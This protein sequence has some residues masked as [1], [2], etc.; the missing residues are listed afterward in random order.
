MS[1]AT[2]LLPT[3]QVACACQQLQT[4]EGFPWARYLPKPR[5]HDA[6]GQVG[7]PFRD[8]LFSPAVTLWAFLSQVLDHDHSCRQVMARLFA[9]LVARGRRPRSADTGAYCKA[10]ARFPEA[11]LRHLARDTGRQP[12]DQ[13]PA[14]WLWKGRVVKVVDGTGLSMPD[15]PANQKEYPHH[16][17]QKPGAGFPLMRLVVV[18]A[19]ATGTAV[20]A[21]LGRWQGKETGEL[22]LFSSLEGALDRSDVL[23]AD[24]G[25]C[26]YFVVAAAL[27][28]GADVVRRLP[29]SRQVN[30]QAG[31]RLGPWR[32][33]LARGPAKH[34]RE[35]T[36]GRTPEK[37]VAAG[38]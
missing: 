21:A 34:R 38:T 31:R 10:R 14:A 13:A 25:F 36:R 15:T 20:D 3:R 30:F 9:W 1:H 4:A 32:H 16:P 11:A 27:A 23:L 18:L 2:P 5:V 7:A 19:L 24:R 22:A 12:L 17:V 37:T 26:S 28:R 35:E 29:C 6:L 8:R 33:V